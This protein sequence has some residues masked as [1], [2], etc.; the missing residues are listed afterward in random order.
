VCRGAITSERKLRLAFTTDPKTGVKLTGVIGR[1]GMLDRQLYEELDGS[2]GEEPGEKIFLFH[3]ALTELKPKELQEMESA[4]VSFL[5]RGFS[6]YA[7]GHVHIVERYAGLGYENIVYPG[8][9]FPN[10]FAEL[11]R[12]RHGGYFLYDDGVV[13][14]RD[15]NLRAVLP[16][17]VDVDGMDAAS[18]NAAVQH[19]VAQTEPEG[20]VVLL[21]IQGVI[22]SGSANDI[23]I[24]SAIRALE[25]H[26]AYIVLRNTARLTS[27]DFAALRV[28]AEE[29]HAIEET[30]LVEHA[31][32]LRM[33]QGDGVALARDLLRQL[34]R[35]P[36]EGEKL[37][38]YQ[39]RMVLETLSRI[40]Q[41]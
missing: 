1:R 18:A 16:M 30:I 41:R 37:H 3:T 19:V 22:A 14:R 7:G 25:E 17:T 9:L 5:P 39:D 40:G 38:E 36:L 8:P 12:L 2:I 23:D 24:R 35:E 20:K 33:P 29:P 11:E 26:G 6:Y 10:S 15:I 27:T 31:D 32:Q 13:T 4:P 28:R 34:S 21:R